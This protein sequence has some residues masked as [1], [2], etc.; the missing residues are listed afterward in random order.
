MRVALD[1]RSLASPGLRGWDRYT[2]GLV[3]ELNTRDVEV[4]LVHTPSRLPRP[5]HLAGL[6]VT[7]TEVEASSGLVWEQWALPRAV[8]RLGCDVYHAPCEH[9]LPLVCSVPTVL[10]I[11]SMTSH[12]YYEMV[13]TGV[14]EG[15]VSRYLGYDFTPG[16]WS[17]TGRY[18]AWQAARA[19]HIIAPSQYAA[20]EIEQHLGIPPARVTVTPL[21]VPDAILDPIDD[22][23]ACAIRDRLHLRAPYV[24]CVG[25]FE[26][27]KNVDGVLDVFGRVQSAHPRL[28][29][30]VVGSGA[31]PERFT[32]AVMARG[33]TMGHDVVPLV[34]VGAELRAVYRG[35]ACLLS[36]SWRE[37]FGLPALE[38]NVLGVPVVTSRYGASEEVLGVGAYLVDPTDL[39]A[40]SARVGQIVRTGERVSEAEVARLRERFTWSALGRATVEV[41]SRLRREP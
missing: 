3:R 12:S 15:P 2:I 38:A 31:V 34:D 16:E 7:M 4:L 28:Q 33:M 11:H 35:A 13:R 19:D 18:Q 24:V 23:S 10:T 37:S 9:G 30:V 25:G 41:Y 5:E 21:G 17:F 6:R 1:G 39:D 20:R 40:A 32:R 26:P 14:L 8:A 36:L 27:H 29:L 22:S